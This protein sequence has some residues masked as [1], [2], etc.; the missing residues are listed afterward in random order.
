MLAAAYAEV[1]RFAEALETVD[2][3]LVIARARNQLEL[4]RLFEER[5]QLYL[6]GRPF[7]LPLVHDEAGGSP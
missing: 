4:I 6:A 2:Q 1:G 5:R 3:G 7:R